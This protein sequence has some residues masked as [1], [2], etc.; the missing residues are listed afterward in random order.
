MRSAHPLVVGVAVVWM[1]V[2]GACERTGCAPAQGGA[3]EATA[4]T[5][6]DE[7]PSALREAVAH[8]ARPAEDR[9]R[10]GDRKPARVLAFFG[11]EPGMKVAE[12]M[13]GRG[14]YA[15]I[16][17]RAVGS[18]GTVYVHNTPYVVDKFADGPLTERLDQL[19]LGNTVRRDRPLEDPGLPEGELDAVLMILFY[20]DTYWM[21]V[22]RD[23][24]NAAIYAALKPG[25]VFGVVDHHARQGAGTDEVKSLH[26]IEPHIVRREILEAGFE[27]D[28]ESDLLRHPEDDRTTNVFDDAI[29]GETDR[30]VFRFRKPE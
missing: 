7:V 30:F 20:H 14:Y 27:L 11:I 23:A 1:A 6:V 10:D 13:A 8:G 24:M 21:D 2:V 12:M 25:G 17:A 3:G 22:D 16:L 19:G 18:D 15:E 29:A 26:R 28:A 5:E 9:A 4:A